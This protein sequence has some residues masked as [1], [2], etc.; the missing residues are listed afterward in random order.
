MQAVLVNNFEFSELSRSN[1]RQ[2]QTISL[3]CFNQFFSPNYCRIIL[4]FHS[5]FRSSNTLRPF[6]HSDVFC[7]RWN[8]DIPI[9]TRRVVGMG[10]LMRNVPRRG[11]TT[12]S[13][14]GGAPR[15]LYLSLPNRNVHYIIKV[16][17][18]VSRFKPWT[19]WLAK[20]RPCC[21]Y[22]LR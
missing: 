8:K 19:D 7:R 9:L 22:D 3:N 11:I 15:I 21:A 14:R 17:V 4:I 2:L 6:C 13:F 10:T 5:C 12:K 18:E 1:R 16:L 20:M